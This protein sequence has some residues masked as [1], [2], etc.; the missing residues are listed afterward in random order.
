M[1]VLIEVGD[2]E[3]PW[4]VFRWGFDSDGRDKPR[5][6]GYENFIIKIEV[7]GKTIFNKKVQPSSQNRQSAPTAKKVET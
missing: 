1:K 5:F 3:C 4:G 7:D 2:E 6:E